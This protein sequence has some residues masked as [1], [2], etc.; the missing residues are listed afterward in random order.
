MKRRRLSVRFRNDSSLSGAVCLFDTD[1]DDA[2]SLPPV[3]WLTCYAFPTTEVEFRWE[4][5]LSFVWT[6]TAMDGEAEVA[7]SQLWPTDLATDNQVTLSYGCGTY[8]FRDQ[9]RGPQPGILYIQQDGT[10]P[11]EGARVGF[12][13]AGRA[14]NLLPARPNVTFALKPRSEYWIAFGHYERG[15]VIDPAEAPTKARLH[16]P[17]NV[18]TLFATLG[19]DNL[20][21]IAP[22]R[23]GSRFQRQAGRAKRSPPA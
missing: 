18:R 7:T 12:G 23:G 9:T 21:T 15:V 20:W 1:P 11:S 3:A 17:P 5:R 19:F 22:A 4:E 13:I 6:S 10:L 2:K 14:T 8:F 16:F